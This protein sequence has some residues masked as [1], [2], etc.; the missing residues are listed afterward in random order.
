MG[1]RRATRRLSRLTV[2]LGASSLQAR[3]ISYRINENTPLNILAPGVLAYVS[4]QIAGLTAV[5]IGGPSHG[6]L[7]SSSNG[8][9]VYTPGVNYIGQDSFQYQA[10]AG[11]T[12]SNVA[13]VFVTIV[14]GGTG[15]QQPPRLLPIHRHYNM[16]RRRRSIDPA[17]F[18]FYHP[19]V[20]ALI[21]MEISGI[22]TTPTEIVSVNAHFN[23]A[24]DRKL[25]AKNPGQF[26]K[27]Q[28]ILGALFAL[29]TPGNGENL[30]PGTAYYVEQKSL[31]EQNP[32]R[33]Q[34]K[35]AYLAAIFAIEE[36]VGTGSTTVPTTAAQ[37]RSVAFKVNNV[38]PKTAGGRFFAGAAHGKAF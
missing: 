11:A 33:Y 10:Q 21:G 20:G 31:F 2:A 15:S 32:A 18:D 26:D 22:P 35:N 16:L 34:L 7:S 4:P 29:E 12:T 36:F 17:R 9:F 23:A 37:S 8:S 1:S 24:A 14:A 30:L 38:Y 13:T 25:H 19:Q 3:N 5:F 28:P 27:K 6:A